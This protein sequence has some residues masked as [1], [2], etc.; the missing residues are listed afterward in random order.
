MPSTVGSANQFLSLNDVGQL[1]WVTMNSSNVGIGEVFAWP[2]DAVAPLDGLYCDG[3]VVSRTTYVDLFNVVG[4]IYG[5]GDGSTTF[6]L[7]DLRG[8][9]LR[10]VDSGAGVDPNAGA[11]TAR[12]DGVSG[13]NVGT[14][15]ADAT[16]KNG[17]TASS[18]TDGAHTHTYTSF[19]TSPATASV[20]EPA[21]NDGNFGNATTSSSGSHSHTITIG[22]GDSETRPVN[23]SVKYY[24]RYQSFQTILGGSGGSSY[25][26]ISESSGNTVIQQTLVT[27]TISISGNAFPIGGVS[28][29][30]LKTDAGGNLVWGSAGSS[31]TQL[32]ETNGNIL[33]S[34]NL[35]VTGS[36][37]LGGLL[38][39]TTTGSANQVLTTDGTGNLSFQNP[40]ES[41]PSALGQNTD[42][43]SGT[44]GWTSGSN[45]TVS[46]ETGSNTL[47]GSQSLSLSKNAG[48]G[49]GNYI[50]Y[51]FTIARADL[52]KM[53]T[54]TFDV[55]AS[56]AN[57]ADNDL[58]IEIIKDPNGTPSTIRMNGEGIKGGIYQHVAQFQS[59]AT[60]TAY[61]LVVKINSSNANTYNVILDNITISHKAGSLA[62]AMIGWE[63]YTPIW[64][65]ATT[66]PA[67]GNGTLTGRWKRNGSNMDVQIHVLM[68]STTSMG[69][70]Q[71]TF[72]LPTGYVID[73]SKLATTTFQVVG[74]A[75]G[76]DIGVAWKD[77][78]VV[79]PNVTDPTVVQVISD[80][81][82][83]TW[84]SDLP[85]TWV[86]TDYLSMTFLC[87]LRGG[88]ALLL[89]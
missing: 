46:L 89:F 85:F 66:N 1:E 50:V 73:N 80:G 26:S 17:L 69:S 86:S 70:N 78:S 16:A 58:R 36:S 52:S 77:G 76:A 27:P 81:G 31:F 40:A 82:N 6:N 32:S 83:N 10:G 33:T 68:G 37:N 48:N 67:I 14:G 63:T 29:K 55:D 65:G 21:N 13:D 43:E 34:G 84:K 25:S 35:T 3:S 28:G 56:H 87:L 60:I 4:V 42:F 88:Q 79:V 19:L 57:Y 15:Q 30:V 49:S 18:S 64:T 24:I 53:L 75:F 54:V 2:S 45:L 44:S 41:F 38:L 20:H 12:A 5:V 47:R 23:I 39:P 59:D 62:T 8:Q 71:W 51:P 7:P 74:S 72:S 22:A 11:R 9:F 61:Q